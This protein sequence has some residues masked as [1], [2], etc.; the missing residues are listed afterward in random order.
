MRALPRVRQRQFAA[1]P[2]L[3][4]HMLNTRQPCLTF[5]LLIAF[6][7]AVIRRE[8]TAAARGRRDRPT[9]GRTDRPPLGPFS[10]PRCTAPPRSASRRPKT[11]AVSLTL[12]WLAAASCRACQR[13]NGEEGKRH[14]FKTGASAG[15]GARRARLLPA[16]TAGV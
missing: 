5:H 13:Q 7:G 3:R 14:A 1:S 15:E 8:C 2:K 9:D 12:A 6:Y 11:G 10:A 4:A 16:N